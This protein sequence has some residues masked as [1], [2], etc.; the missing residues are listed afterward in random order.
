MKTITRDDTVH[1]QHYVLL[2]DAQ[3]AVSA[4][5]ERYALDVHSCHPQCMKAGC[6]N[7]RLREQLAGLVRVLDTLR[8]VGATRY[9]YAQSRAGH[10]VH[11]DTVIEAA[12][13]ELQQNDEVE[14][15][16][17]AGAQR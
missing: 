16:R 8:T 4:E 15:P 13:A 1:G 14:R 17:A 11:V 10:M 3:A 5:R 7:A 9:P 2:A 12:R 6:V